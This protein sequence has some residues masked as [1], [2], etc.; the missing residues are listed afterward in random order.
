MPDPVTIGLTTAA[1][2]GQLLQG[3]AG[4]KGNEQARKAAERQAAFTFYQRQEERRQQRRQY[5]RVLGENRARVH[6]SNLQM[7][8]SSAAVIQEMEG[9]FLRDLNT[10]YN[11]ALAERNAI[12]AGGRGSDA[13]VL[14]STALNVGTTLLGVI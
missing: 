1:I 2:G 3:A 7:S 11:A 12:K 13:A 14:G 9:E 6:A 8:G 10:R 4:L 5:D